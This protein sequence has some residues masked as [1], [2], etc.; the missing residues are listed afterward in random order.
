MPDTDT[1]Q[2]EDVRRG[3]TIRALREANGLTAVELGRLIGV[4]EPLITAI[5][6]GDRRATMANCR[7]IAERLNVPLAAITIEDYAL[8][9]AG[10]CECCGYKPGTPG[11]ATAHGIAEAV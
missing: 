6:R 7:A 1:R 9:S 8:T 4:S 2:P 3:A 11:Y 5:E 10:H